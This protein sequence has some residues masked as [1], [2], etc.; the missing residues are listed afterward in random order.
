MPRSY[1]GRKDLSRDK[2]A[3]TVAFL[4]VRSK[5]RFAVGTACLRRRSGGTKSDPLLGT[6]IGGT[7][8]DLPLFGIPDHQ[9]PRR[10]SEVVAHTYETR[11]FHDGFMSAMEVAED[12]GPRSIREIQPQP[13]QFNLPT[14]LQWPRIKARGSDVFRNASLQ[15]GPP[16]NP[17]AN[18]RRAGMGDDQFRALLVEQRG[19]LFPVAPQDVIGKAAQKIVLLGPIYMQRAAEEANLR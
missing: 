2:P 8:Q 13:G 5:T 11:I 19:G 17:N 12:P 16:L 9:R 15:L 1:V 14:I 4:P 6:R 18:A 7:T 10:S 3:P